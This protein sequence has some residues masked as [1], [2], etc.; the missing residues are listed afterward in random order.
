MNAMSKTFSKL[1]IQ[2]LAEQIIELQYSQ[3]AALWK[4][5]DPDGRAKSI[6]DAG[7]HLTY[8]AEAMSAAEPALF[9]EYLAWAKILF[10]GLK[11]RDDILLTTLGYTR[12]V[13]SKALEPDLAQIALEF[14]DI[15]AK[16]LESINAA[17]ESFLAPNLPLADLAQN[18]LHTL[19]MGNRRT[20]TQMILNAVEQG[21]PVKDIYLN[22]FQPSQR[23]IGRLWQTNQISV[24]QEHFCTATTQAI[25]SQLYPYIFNGSKKDR[26]MVVACVGGE[27]HE[28]GA[29]MVADFC[30]MEG[31]DTYF[32][33]ANTPYQSILSAV[34]ERRAEV[35]AISATMTFHVS[36]VT[37]LIAVARA[38]TSTTHTHILVGGYPFNLSPGL[39]ERVGADGYAP[40]A[41][42]ALVE[43][44]KV[45]QA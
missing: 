40:D 39:W 24:A 41:Q 22:I 1:Q 43:A 8:L 21:T 10:Q 12:Q 36:E 33:G 23:E 37:S 25:M 18:F 19:L 3:Q 15:G 45:W 7:Y 20:A 38:N 2:T 6:R 44:D 32:L 16:S 30:E 35:L 5:Y 9:V 29:R 34:S 17:P 4:P 26:R 13:L 42:T 14:I 28:I 27:L 11:F 31:W